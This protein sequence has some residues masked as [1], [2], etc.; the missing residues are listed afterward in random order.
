MYT[1]RKLAA[2]TSKV[3]HS[4]TCLGMARNNGNPWRFGA[5]IEFSLEVEEAVWPCEELEAEIS[6]IAGGGKLSG[7][8]VWDG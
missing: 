4:P 6:L 2:K 8:V 3:L 5:E 1:C 7:S